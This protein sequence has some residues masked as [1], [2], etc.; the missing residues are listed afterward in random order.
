MFTQ[1]VKFFGNKIPLAFFK[2]FFKGA[3]DSR[4]MM[5]IGVILKVNS[6]FYAYKVVAFVS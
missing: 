1:S 3:A 6:Q 4:E 5:C 2:N